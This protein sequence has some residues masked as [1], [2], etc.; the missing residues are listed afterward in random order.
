[1]KTS[2][3]TAVAT[4]AVTGLWW[5]QAISAEAPYLD[6]RSD[7]AA[8]VR[9][10]YNAVSRQEYARAWDYFGDAKPAKDFDA[11]VKGYAETGRVDVETGAVSSE[12]AAGS[13]FYN[14]P[15]AI[16]AV[17]SD[18]AEKVFAGCY[19]AR[20]VNASIQEPPFRPIQLEKGEL[21]PAE[22]NLV[23]VLPAK[24][25][26]AP[27]V[28]TDAVFDL[29]KKLFASSHQ[30]KCD[31]AKEGE[32]AALSYAISYHN[33]ADAADAAPSQARL[34]RFFCSMGAYNESHV[35]YLWN[36]AEG[37]RELHFAVPDLDIHYEND[38]SDGKLEGV[39]IIGFRSEGEL[40]NSSYDEKTMS[41]T[42]N[43]KWRG[44]GDASTDGLW[45]FRD[46]DFSL[47]KYDVDASYD[48]EVNPETILDYNTGP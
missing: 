47:V 37:L 10:L 7:P 40:V 11:F 22:G 43:A 25:G 30:A 19:T 44:V 13:I 36:E 18:G 31:T 16:R 38:N 39:D 26:D 2:S 35:Y 32:D 34:F 33:K 3:I 5:V 48:G 42:S 28:R 8:V 46:G 17:G 27:P 6:D 41:L 20:Q 4:L 29:A 45:I 24:C 15:V 14:I 9:S 12:G 21:K 23:D 1:M